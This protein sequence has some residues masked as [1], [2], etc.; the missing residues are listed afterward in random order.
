MVSHFRPDDNRLWGGPC[1]GFADGGF[2]EGLHDGVAGVVGMNGLIHGEFGFHCAVGLG[3]RGVVVQVDDVLAAS[4][5]AE[6][7][8]QAADAVGRGDARV[9]RKAVGRRNGGQDETDVVLTGDRDHGG[10]IVFRIWL[11]R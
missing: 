4:V 10:N 8:V 9:P 5:G 3:E 1:E 6:C 2:G 7:D 11:V